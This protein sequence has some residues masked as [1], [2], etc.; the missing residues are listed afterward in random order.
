MD[1][2]FVIGPSAVGKTTLAKKLYNHYSGV[3]IEQNMVPEF[4]IPESVEDVGLYEEQLC[5]ENTLAQIKFFYDKGL[6]NIVAL[7]FDDIRARELPKIFQGYNF[8]IIRLVSSDSNQ[9]KVQME[10][11]KNNEGGLFNPDYV[12]RANSVIKGRKLLPNEVMVDVAGK[13]K[14]GV[15]AEV[16]SL[17]D[18]FEP[19]KD[20]AYELDDEKH[21]LSWV[22]SRKLI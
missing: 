9:I 3:Y 22:K 13:D 16:M 5:W 15:F 11:R 18:N 4:V 10:H 21:Y 7:D 1:F 6:R 2:I 17:I 20:Y 8:I 14:Q 19:V 12:E